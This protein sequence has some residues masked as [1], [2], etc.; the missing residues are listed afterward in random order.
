MEKNNKNNKII[1][2]NINP[3]AS[4]VL[5]NVINYTK[6]NA[7]NVIWVKDKIQKVDIFVRGAEKMCLKKNLIK[8]NNNAM[9]VLYFLELKK[10]T[11]KY[12]NKQNFNAIYVI[13]NFISYN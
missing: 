10:I 3:N 8:I 11:I 12:K 2:N 6:V 7:A 4:I 13:N 9:I 1:Y 5:K